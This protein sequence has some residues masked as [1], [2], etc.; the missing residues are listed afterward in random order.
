MISSSINESVSVAGY[1]F[2]ISIVAW[3]LNSVF[4]I[5]FLLHFGRNLLRLLILNFKPFF[6]CQQKSMILAQQFSVQTRFSFRCITPRDAFIS[7]NLKSMLVIPFCDAASVWIEEYFQYLCHVQHLI[8][9][10]SNWGMSVPSLFFI[11]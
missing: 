2:L 1:L 11:S 8:F 3:C 5:D 7:S 6:H 4:H 10:A 9:I